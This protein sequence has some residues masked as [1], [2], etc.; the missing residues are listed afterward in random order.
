M[1][2]KILFATVSTGLAAMYDS[3]PLG[4]KEALWNLRTWKGEDRKLSINLNLKLLA[5]DDE[6]IGL[7]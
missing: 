2:G 6:V 1:L 4:Q 5:S 7:V 3:L